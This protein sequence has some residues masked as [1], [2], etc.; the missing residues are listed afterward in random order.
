MTLTSATQLVCR[1]SSAAPVTA[2]TTMV[3]KTPSTT[4]TTRS[5]IIEN[6][7]SLRVALSAMV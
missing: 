2:L 6:P 1:A 7:L 5:S 3:A 4:M